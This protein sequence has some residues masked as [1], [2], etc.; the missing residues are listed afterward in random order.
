MSLWC[1]GQFI[2]VLVS[3]DHCGRIYESCNG[4]SLRCNNC[5]AHDI[6]IKLALKPNTTIDCMYVYMRICVVTIV[7]PWIV[8]QREH[9]VDNYFTLEGGMYALTGI[10][11]AWL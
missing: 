2:S 8:P 9:C 11:G 1:S 4:C 10:Y 3:A 7:Y 5:S 6:S